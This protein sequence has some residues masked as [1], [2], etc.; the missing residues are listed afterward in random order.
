M[1][2]F[3]LSITSLLIFMI[4]KLI[5]YLTGYNEGYNKRGR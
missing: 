2:Y 4:G 3:V 1:M 5:G